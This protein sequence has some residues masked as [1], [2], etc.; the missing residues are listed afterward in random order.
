MSTLDR[1]PG[2]RSRPVGHRSELSHRLADLLKSP[3][4]IVG[5]IFGSVVGLGSGRHVADRRGHR[6]RSGHRRVLSYIIRSCRPHTPP[7]PGSWR[8]APLTTTRPPASRLSQPRCLLRPANPTSY[9]AS[10]APVVPASM[11]FTTIQPLPLLSPRESLF[12]HV[13]AAVCLQQDCRGVSPT[14]VEG[15]P[16]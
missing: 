15:K 14:A 10:S 16:I 2:P 6:W 3:F 1:A 7:R 9:P 13:P 8:C 12:S 5:S 11:P 4:Q